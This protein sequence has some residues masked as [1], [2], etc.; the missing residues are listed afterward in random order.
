[1]TFTLIID[2]GDDNDAYKYPYY[3]ED[4]LEKRL[5]DLS[6]N[7]IKSVERE[8]RGNSYY[9]FK[10]QFNYK[11]NH[12]D[13]LCQDIIEQGGFME[14]TY[15]NGLKEISGEKFEFTWKIAIL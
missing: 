12:M 5:Y 11:S 7:L 4:V 14:Y 1:M 13:D 9:V 15:R 6:G 3:L 10:V 8:E 2:V